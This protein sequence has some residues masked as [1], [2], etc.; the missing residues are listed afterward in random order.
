M[1]TYVYACAAYR[2][3]LNI[4]P[5]LNVSSFL[6]LMVSMKRCFVLGNRNKLFVYM[7]VSTFPH[8]TNQTINQEFFWLLCATFVGW[9]VKNAWKMYQCRFRS[10]V[11]F[12]PPL[13][14]HVFGVHMWTMILKS[15][16]TNLVS[17]VFRLKWTLINY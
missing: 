6:A 1:E 13:N 14:S 9:F 3:C 16:T 8:Q 12:H 11:F 7:S 5:W 10:W 17:K 15:G 2:G 4:R